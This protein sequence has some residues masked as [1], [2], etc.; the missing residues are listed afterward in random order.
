MSTSQRAVMLCGWGVKAGM[1][2]E[3]V[4]GKTVWSPC[5]HGPYLSALAMGSS[6][7]RALYK[8][9]ITWCFTLVRQ[10]ATCRFHACVYRRRSFY[11]IFNVLRCRPIVGVSYG[12]RESQQTAGSVGTA[13]WRHVSN[14]LWSS[15]WDWTEKHRW[16]YSPTELG[17][18]WHRTSRK[19]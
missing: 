2:R 4:T 5:Y 14:V 7:N 15:L 10:V 9:P 11:R 1:L 13:R 8:C 18:R 17:C 19:W 12:N 3:W 6:H 16:G